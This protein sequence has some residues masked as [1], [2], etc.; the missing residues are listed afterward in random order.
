MRL[1][2]TVLLTSLSRSRFNKSGAGNPLLSQPFEAG[3]ASLPS[4]THCKKELKMDGE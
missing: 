3:N 4:R 1:P 2:E